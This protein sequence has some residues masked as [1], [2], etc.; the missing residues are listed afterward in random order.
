MASNVSSG[1][2]G[3]SR[4]RRR[5][6]GSANRVLSPIAQAS[7]ARD[8][9]EI[10]TED[11]ESGNPEDQSTDESDS[12]TSTLRRN[13]TSGPG[14]HSM[15]GSYRRQSFAPAGARA[16]V[17]PGLQTSHRDPTKTERKE[18]LREER[19]LLRDNNVIPPKHPQNNDQPPPLREAIIQHIPSLGIPGGDRRVIAAEEAAKDGP[20]D[21]LTEEAPLLENPSLPYGGNDS[22]EELNKRWEE[23]VMSGKIQTTWQ[24]EAKVLSRYSLPL[25]T[26][27]FLQYSLTVA[28]VFT[29]GHIGKVELSAVSLASMTA[30]ITGYGIYWGLTT[31]LDTLCSQAYGS[32]KKEL[33][34]LQF[35]RMVYFLLVCSIPIGIIWLSAESILSAI[36]P[37]KDVAVLAGHYLRIILIGAPGYLTFEA[38]KKY[39]QAQGIFFASLY[40]LLICAPLNVLMNY[41]FVWQ[42][43]WGFT[44]APIAVAITDLLLPFCLFLYV[45]FINGK[46]CWPG[47][48]MRAF[49]NWTPMM[50]LAL[51]GLLTVEAEILAFEI[52]TLAA[53]YFGTTY[54]AAQS[55]LGTVIGITYQ[56][57]FPVSIAASTR[58]ANLVGATLTP[59]A[60]TAT[61]VTLIVAMVIGSMNF[62][63]LSSLRGYIPQLFTSD[64]DVIALV[65]RVLPICALF[66]LWDALA[67]NCNGIL[68]GLGR[69]EI[70]GYVQLGAYYAVGI[71]LSFGTGFGLHWGIQGFWAGVAVALFL[72]SVIELGF[73]WKTDWARAVEDARIRN[74]GS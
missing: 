25:I 20:P 74:E 11:L 12:E 62:L 38:G 33:V 61:K 63:L 4:S 29:V 57:P 71:P 68:R 53:S 6:Y 27:F 7:I 66:Q 36:V 18:A 59:A 49:H 1:Q 5:S 34:G 30:N 19:N 43:G 48:T 55:I 46:A 22:P 32:G 67:A 24:R 26:T 16:A 69:Q 15:I 14:N 9:E 70:G 58:I 64:P 13:R 65:A 52:L 44:G 42:F 37:E 56:I 47:F 8:L 60:K 3:P 72:V 21:D 2:H 54:L 39:L 31:S 45:Y 41:L 17:A 73:I 28:S 10:P 40:V 23:A 35:Q 51:P 50:K